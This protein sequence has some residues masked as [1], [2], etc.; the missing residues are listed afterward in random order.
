MP[1]DGLRKVQKMTDSIEEWRDVKGYEGLYQVS[2]LG[3]VRSYEKSFPN[4]SN[5]EKMITVPERILKPLN[6]KGYMAVT[7]YKDRKPKQ[8]RIHR[9]VAEYFVDNPFGLNEVDHIDRDKTNNKA[10]NLR[11][12]TT[13][14][15]LR[16]RKAVSNTGRKYIH[17]D[18]SK[19]HDWYVVQFTYKDE[20][21]YKRFRTIEQALEY[22]DSFDMEV[23]E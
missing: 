20:K 2:N 7:L 23:V 10:E 6:P 11:W 4:P 18:T 21:I 22:R 19:K 16:N 12:V 1:L 15:N 5:P 13:S 14:E 17:R 8:V 9:L 3:R